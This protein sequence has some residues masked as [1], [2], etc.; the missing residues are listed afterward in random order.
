M[1][2]SPKKD[3]SLTES[4]RQRQR[5]KRQA[6]PLFPHRFDQLL[7]GHFNLIACISRPNR[8]VARLLFSL[9]NDQEV[10]DP[11]FLTV[12]NFFPHGIV[13]V[14]YVY[15]DI[16]GGDLGGEALGKCEV[17]LADRE[18]A[19]LCGRKPDLKHR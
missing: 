5:S 12:S 10:G 19:N 9:A 1:T 16:P 17:V 4:H 3:R 2:F 6:I 7:H 8:K 11:F 18:D 15:P 14:I 13:P